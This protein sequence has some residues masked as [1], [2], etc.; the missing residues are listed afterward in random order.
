MRELW[1]L[2]GGGV[3]GGLFGTLYVTQFEAERKLCAQK[4]RK[5]LYSGIKK[6]WLIY[7]M[8]Y[9]L[10]IKMNEMMPFAATRICN[11]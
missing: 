5:K 7:A 8:Q 6:I 10:A 11:A 2:D 4:T 1:D 9:Y 3:L